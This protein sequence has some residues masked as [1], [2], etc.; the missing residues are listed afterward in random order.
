[1]DIYKYIYLYVYPLFSLI[2]IYIKPESIAAL[3]DRYIPSFSTIIT[4]SPPLPLSYISI[5]LCQNQSNQRVRRSIQPTQT[6]EG[7]PTR[8]EDVQYA[9]PLLGSPIQLLQDA[10]VDARDEGEGTT[11]QYLLRSCPR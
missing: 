7:Y 4:L 5:R 1:M 6:G 11:Y 8:S 3:S 9:P 10:G 2:I